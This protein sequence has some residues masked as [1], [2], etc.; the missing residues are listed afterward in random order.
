M[1]FLTLKDKWTKYNAWVK[2]RQEKYFYLHT[3]KTIFKTREDCLDESYYNCA[4]REIINNNFKGWNCT[5]NCFPSPMVS[6]GPFDKS[7]ICETESEQDC[8]WDNFDYYGANCSKSCSIVQ[9]TGRIDFW[10]DSESNLDDLSF[11]L[12][13]RFAPPLTSTVYQEYIVYDIFGM[14]GTVGGT[15]GIFI[16]F[17]CS[18]L[19]TFIT[20]LCK[21]Q[22]FQKLKMGCF[23]FFKSIRTKLSSH[24]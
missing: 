14:I 18:S 20:D 7:L 15:L 22:E 2:I 13:L 21:K 16:G 17:S 19:L 1:I 12:N 9:Y 3:S 24:Q 11:T 23:R 8:S 5:K 6:S 4:I 10:G